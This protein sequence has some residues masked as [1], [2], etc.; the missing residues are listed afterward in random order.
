RARPCDSPAVSQRSMLPI[1]PCSAHWRLPGR[2]PGITPAHDGSRRREPVLRAGR[3][4]RGAS[5]RRRPRALRG[6]NMFMRLFR[7]AVVTALLAVPV[8]ATAA[9]DAMAASPPAASP[10]A[11][12]AQP[13]AV[14]PGAAVTFRVTCGS[15]KTHDAT[16]LGTRL[17][18]AGR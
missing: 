9:P 5:A 18:L 10:P 13:A 11:A 16:L 7:Y 15:S 6:R 1:L 17:G 12:T 14:T 4:R 8:L 3:A 2:A